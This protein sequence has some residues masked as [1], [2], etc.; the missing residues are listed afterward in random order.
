[1][2]T[3]R[4]RCFVSADLPDDLKVA[5]LA[6][7]RTI[8]QRV[9]SVRLTRVSNLHLTLKFL[10]E[11]STEQMDTVGVRLGDVEWP[12]ATLQI[13]CTGAF[14]PRIVWVSISGAEA[15]QRRVDAALSGIFEPEA[16]FMGHVTIGRARRL[17]RP[18]IEAIEDVLALPIDAPI[19]S[20]SISTARSSAETGPTLE[21]G[22]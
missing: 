12:E 17:T 1:M 5:I 10:G 8:G 19:A 6:A 2:P 4:H 11:I 22:T 7:Q 3:G 18:S 13:G 9:K 21:P 14:A 15:L 20:V 16:R